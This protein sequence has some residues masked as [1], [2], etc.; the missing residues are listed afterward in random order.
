[1]GRRR[2]GQ[3]YGEDGGS[4]ITRGVTEMGRVGEEGGGRKRKG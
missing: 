4:E 3:R 1:M 2:E